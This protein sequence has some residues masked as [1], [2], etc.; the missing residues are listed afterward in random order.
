LDQLPEGRLLFKL[1]A[2]RVALA[3]GA[4]LLFPFFNVFFKQRFGVTDSTLGWILGVTDVLVALMI[5]G[6]GLAA[7]RLGKIRAL[8]IAR[9]I[10]TPLLL[11]IGFV[12]WLPAAVLAHWVRS[13][14]MRLGGPLYMAF[15]MEQLDENNR[16][17]GSSMLG[18]TWDLGY[19][20][21]P[22]ISGLVQ[23]RYG[24]S[25]LFWA[26]VALYGLSLGLVYWFFGQGRASTAPVIEVKGAADP[27]SA[28]RE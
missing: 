7:E 22:Y 18:M 26:T 4:G 27:A 15:A 10:S 12:P 1:L 17:T 16:A 20:V 13:G 2:P 5:L 23:V 25:P 14:L 24:F 21:A 11:V 9:M 19:A 6:G 28:L 8:L 3:L